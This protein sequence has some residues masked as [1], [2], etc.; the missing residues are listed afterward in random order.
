MRVTDAK[1]F[2]EVLRKR[3]KELNYTQVYLSEFTGFSVSF[4]SELEN[5]KVT[6]E[7]GKAFHLMNILGLNCEL[8]ERGKQK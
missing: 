5:G 7:I 8:T 2:G 1:S 4:I 3:R 6:A